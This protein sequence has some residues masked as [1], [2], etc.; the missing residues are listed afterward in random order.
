MPGPLGDV[1]GED[2]VLA[3]DHPPG[4][5]GRDVGGGDALV[6]D[7]DLDQVPR[8]GPRGQGDREHR[9]VPGPGLVGESV[10]EEAGDLQAHEVQGDGAGPHVRGVEQDVQGR[11]PREGLVV[12]PEI[13]LQAVVGDVQGA[14][15][16]REEQERC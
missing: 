11:R 13:D 3:P 12:R 10:H 6:P 7:L 2:P 8:R 16:G 15:R 4:A 14:G 1:D 9:A 5:P